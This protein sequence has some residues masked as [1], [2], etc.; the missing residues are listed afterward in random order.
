MKLKEVY[1]NNKARIY[2]NIINIKEKNI[3][4]ETYPIK[5]IKDNW[6]QLL[7]VLVAFIAMLLINFNL[8]YFLISFALI[9]SLLIIFIFGNKSYLSCNKDSLHIKQRISKY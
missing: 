3:K 7:A 9:F 5:K 4:L 8:N 1:L 2:S 6:I